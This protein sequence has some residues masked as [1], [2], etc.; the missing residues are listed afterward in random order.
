MADQG[1][2]KGYGDGTFQPD[3]VITRAELHLIVDSLGLSESNGKGFEDTAGHWAEKSIKTASDNGIINGYNKNSFGPDDSITREQAADILAK[4]M[5]ITSDTGQD[6]VDS[7]AISYWAL[8][9]VKSASAY[10]IISGYPDGSFKP[11]ANVTRAQAA[12]ILQRSIQLM[13]NMPV[14]SKEVAVSTPPVVL[15]MLPVSTYSSSGGGAPGGGS[16]SYTLT[17]EASPETGGSVS[18][19][20][21]FKE[22]VTVTVSATAN[23]GY[24]LKNW[25]VN[26]AEVSTASAFDLFMPAADGVL[27]ANFAKTYTL[28]V[29]ANPSEG[30]TASDTAGTGPYE[31]GTLVNVKAEAAAGYQ[32]ENWTVNDTVVSTT[33]EHTYIVP[34]TDAVLVANFAKTYTLI[35]Q[36]YPTGGGDVSDNTG[37]G[38]Y[39]AG[40]SVDVAAAAG[41]GYTFENW[42]V[43]GEVVNTNASFSYPM[44]AADTILVANF[45]E[46]PVVPDTYALTLQ[47]NPTGGGDV[48]NNTGTGSYEAG[49]SVEIA[50]VAKDGYTFE[51]WT[52]EGG[53]VVSSS[54]SFRFTMPDADTTLVANF[55]EEAVEPETYNLSLQVSPGGGGTVTDNTDAG[56]YEAGESVDVAAEAAEGYT[57]ENW[58]V[59]GDVVNTNASFTYIMPAEDVTLAGNFTAVVVE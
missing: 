11:K 6:F 52:L 56:P 34:T 35:L 28:I 20:G 59:N 46:D 39:E 48:S 5:K 57:F 32:F 1:R 37:T 58:T 55:T 50:A 47:A 43:N 24:T 41:E 51:N 38:P 4:A 3:R 27:V 26:G 54:A 40:E 7:G 30:G 36:A 10:G 23:S 33:A 15:S 2:L 31:A 13:V 25:T 21:S 42:T 18:G 16:K 22:G 19:G 9:S 49:E 45:A 44:P 53:G 17:V 8:A 29:Q 12:V 14:E